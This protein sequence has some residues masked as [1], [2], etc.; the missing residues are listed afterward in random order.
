LPPLPSCT[1]PAPST[2]DA[3]TTYADLGA[4]IT[5]TF[6]DALVAW[7]GSAENGLTDLFAKTCM[8]KMS[9]LTASS[10]TRS[11]HATIA[12]HQ[13]ASPPLNCARSCRAQPSAPHTA[14][15]RRRIR[16]GR[17]QRAERPVH[18]QRREEHGHRQFYSSS[19]NS[20]SRDLTRARTLTGTRKRTARCRRFIRTGTCTSARVGRS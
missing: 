1:S 17:N 4:T 3:S 14:S 20:T 6:K 5:G 18:S 2:C 8:Q 19:G 7:L 16:I 13:S 12:G 15:G 10:A 11:G 9:T